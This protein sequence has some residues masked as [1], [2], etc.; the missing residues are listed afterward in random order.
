M[1]SEKDMREIVKRIV[2]VAD[3]EKIILFG[4]YADGTAKQDSDV[5][6]LVVKETVRSFPEDAVRIRR[7]LDDFGTGFDLLVYDRE[8]FELRRQAK[9]HIAHEAAKT[10]RTLYDR[11]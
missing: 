4:S 9:W 7:S 8:A 3:P 11:G 2:R 5:D 1:L 6:L 10:G